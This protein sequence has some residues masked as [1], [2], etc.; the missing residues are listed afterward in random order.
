M[1]RAAKGLAIRGGQ[2]KQK[3]HVAWLGRMLPLNYSTAA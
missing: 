1:T 2:E 3:E